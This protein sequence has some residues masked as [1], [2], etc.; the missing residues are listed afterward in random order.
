MSLQKASV[1][2]QQWSWRHAQ[3]AELQYKSDESGVKEPEAEGTR[4][5][6]RGIWSRDAVYVLGLYCSVQTSKLSLSPEK[7][8]GA[9]KHGFKQVARQPA[10]PVEARG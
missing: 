8:C 5:I 10:F 2:E 4:Y 9:P 3:E 6:W 1:S 7:H